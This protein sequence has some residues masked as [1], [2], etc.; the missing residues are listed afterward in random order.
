MNPNTLMVYMI[1]FRDEIDDFL[2]SD[3]HTVSDTASTKT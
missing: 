1:N 2:C 3:T